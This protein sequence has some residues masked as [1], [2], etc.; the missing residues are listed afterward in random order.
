[1]VKL[2]LSE[3]RAFLKTPLGL[4]TAALVAFLLA[5]LSYAALAVVSPGAGLFAT[6]LLVLA[7]V[8]FSTF[9]AWPVERKITLQRQAEVIGYRVLAALGVY[10]GLGFAILFTLN[11]FTDYV[12]P[13]DWPSAFLLRVPFW[14]FY[15]L[16][17]LGCYTFLPA[18]VDAP[19]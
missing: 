6:S 1:M 9:A 4:A 14:P 10:I 18:P 19:C 5:V 8:L 12:V 15:S 3:V 2:G 16:V 7:G 17:T 11:T 13:L